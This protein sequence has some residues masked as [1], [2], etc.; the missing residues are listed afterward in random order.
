MKSNHPYKPFIP[1]NADKLIIGTIP[2][3]RFCKVPNEIKKGDVDFYYGSNRNKFWHIISEIFGIIFSFD[4]T[5]IAIEQ[6]KKFLIENK[7]GI[8]DTIKSCIHKNNSSS[9]NDLINI[10]YFDIE[11]L[12][13]RNKNIHTLIY[14]SQFVKKNMNSI[15]KT[16]HR[17]IDDNDQYVNINGKIYFVNILYSPSPQALKY[18]GKN[19]NERRK[20][21]YVDIFF[22][23]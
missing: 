1:K 11:K 7:I 18:L 2:P 10:E 3:P 8:A 12:L 9:D 19:G 13:M 22:K 4:N 21:Q 5:S 14:T 15:L 20:K 23:K 16:F 6:R 17:Y